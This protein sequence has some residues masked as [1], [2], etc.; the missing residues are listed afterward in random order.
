MST[1]QG[2]GQLQQWEGS[3]RFCA[4]YTNF[5]DRSRAR[6]FESIMMTP[7]NTV[8]HWSQRHSVAMSL[9]KLPKFRFVEEDPMYARHTEMDPTEMPVAKRVRAYPATFT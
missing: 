6:S 2:L 8:S 1:T 7:Q 5:W 3:V 9:A 4:V